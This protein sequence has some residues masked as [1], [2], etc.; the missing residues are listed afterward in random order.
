MFWSS[1]NRDYGG[2]MAPPQKPPVSCVGAG[3]REGARL[4][5]WINKEQRGTTRA[6]CGLCD[7]KEAGGASPTGQEI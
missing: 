4:C 2:R 3:P 5:F 1:Q 7:I 6:G